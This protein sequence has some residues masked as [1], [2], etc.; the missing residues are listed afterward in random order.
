[1]Q[2]SYRIFLRRLR[3]ISVKTVE[4][5]QWQT[6]EETNLDSKGTTMSESTS[7]FNIFRPEGK[8]L[9]IL[10]SSPHSGTEFPSEIVS[11]YENKH[12]QSPSDTD[13]LIDKLYDFAPSLGMTQI[14]A[15][16][17]RYVIDLNRSPKG[18]S[19]YGDGRSETNLVPVTTFD[20]EPLFVKGKKPNL[21]EIQR[22]KENY[23]WPYYKQIEEEL[24][25][26]KKEFGK[27]IFFDC[28]SIRRLVK[29]IQ[30][31]PFPDLIIGT[32][33]GKTAE[34][35]LEKKF[36]AVLE[37]SFS[38]QVSYNS[39]FKGGHLTR[40]FGDPENGINA[41]QLEMAQDLYLSEDR[42]E[43]DQS[44]IKPLRN[45]LSEA[46]LALCEEVQK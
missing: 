1:M 20:Q 24:A 34:N 36:Q 17:S 39:P 26:L 35:K 29:S 41:V 9:P 18:E 6:I 33:E 2:M 43:L 11:Q 8:R 4:T 44:K 23:F 13:L 38:Y 22:R 30:P 12:V 37:K 46:L 28:H 21:E 5:T 3:L 31:D 10:L 16:Y 40:Y 25:S 19:L 32:L 45:I 27:V 42:S 7:L 15:N 14:T